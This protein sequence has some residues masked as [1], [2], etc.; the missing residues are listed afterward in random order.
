[1][2][3]GW[4][5]LSFLVSTAVFGQTYYVTPQGN[6]ANNGLRWET[7]WTP[8]K[9]SNAVRPGDTIIVRKGNYKY[10]ATNFFAPVSGGTASA[11]I[12]IRGEN[13]DD[14]PILSRGKGGGFNIR[15]PYIIIQDIGCKGVP[16][17][18]CVSITD[19]HHVTVRR[20]RA[21][22]NYNGVAIR[23]SD[24]NVVEDSIL[25]YNQQGIYVLQGSDRN[26]I[27][28]NRVMYNGLGPKGD[29]DGIAVGGHGAGS[30]N[31]IESN[32]VAHNGLIGIGVFDAPRTVVRNN[33]VY[34]NGSTGI[35]VAVF[36][37][38]SLVDGNRVEGNGTAC[39]KLTNI[40]GITVRT[41]SSGTVVSNN[42]VLNNCVSAGNPWGDKDPRGGIDVRSWRY[43]D[44][45]V[46][47]NVKLLN[48]RVS[49]T[50]NGPDFYV[51]PKANIKELIV[52]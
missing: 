37:T 18:S 31:I 32:I 15:V 52:R 17:A 45:R 50:V 19:T 27:L 3:K 11:P 9:A 46:M 44:P 41:G 1:M 48:N 51:D 25:T 23:N 7:S 8:L 47:Y 21:E 10:D 43:P 20:L 14:P 2:S 26:S 34:D 13:R 24:D 5:F 16:S 33:H 36:S 30:D 39:K 49:G 12:T 6:D 22:N 4:F 42:L 40:A 35:S 38:D 29:R 28:R